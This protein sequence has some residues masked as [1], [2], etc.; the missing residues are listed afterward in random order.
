MTPLF[1]PWENGP[2]HALITKL[3]AHSKTLLLSSAEGG[4]KGDFRPCTGY[5]YLQGFAFGVSKLAQDASTS[6]LRIIW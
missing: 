1:G 6:T 2:D 3:L 4:R 5:Q